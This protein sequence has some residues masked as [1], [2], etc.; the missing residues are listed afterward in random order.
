MFT[1]FTHWLSQHTWL[2][3]ALAAGSLVLLITSVLA[4]P[5]IV[6]QLPAD[7]LLRKEPRSLKHPML[8]L[9]IT[10]MRTLIG[11]TLVLL[12]LVMLVIPG[13]GIVTVL[14]GLSVAQFPGKQ[15]LLCH[16]ASRKSVFSS[17]NW[18]RQRHGKAPLIHPYEGDI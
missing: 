16:I 9:T 12:G 8:K 5:W 2:L 13:P 4:T 10:L 7:Y 17:L 11:A 3:G 15:R 6:A 14:I 1:S 18:M